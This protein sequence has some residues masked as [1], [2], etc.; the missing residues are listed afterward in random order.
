MF[1]EIALFCVVI[2]LLFGYWNVNQIYA[3][4]LK[5]NIPFDKGQFPYGN[6]KDVGEKMHIFELTNNLY[7]R[8]KKQAPVAG[9]HVLT[10]AAV[11]VTDLDVVKRILVSD[12]NLFMDRGIYR[13]EEDPLSGN[14]FNLDG[15]KYK[16]MHNKL[17][18]LFS[19]EKIKLMFQSMEEFADRLSSYFFDFIEGRP[20]DLNLQDILARYSS[21][22]MGTT[23]LGSEC[24]SLRDETTELRRISKK[25]LGKGRERGLKYFF[26][27]TFQETAK[28]IKMTETPKE[29]SDFFVRL[30][31]SSIDNRDTTKPKKN[32]LIELLMS[33]NTNEKSGSLTLHETSAHAYI[34]Y[35][36]GFETLTNTLAFCLYEISKTREIQEILRRQILQVFKHKADQASYDSINEIPYLDQVINETL[37]KHPPAPVLFRTATSDYQL[38]NTNMV[39]PMGTQI[40]I[41]VYAIHHDETIYTKPEAYN[42]DR[43]N[44]DNMKDGHACSFMPF[45]CGPRACIGSKFAMMHLKITLVNLLRKFRFS[46]GSKTPFPLKFD[47]KAAVLSADDIWLT[48]ENLK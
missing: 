26:R 16:E 33:E 11:V 35:V 42:P 29:V 10:N 36:A 47:K 39:I 1:I 45:S 40:M 30:V 3:I 15:P 27:N 13:N 34:F 18:P 19:T 48:V 46:I 25:Y 8:M 17:M 32:N 43:F 41:P 4:W 6:M 38:P 24:N 37:R 9:F 5:C 31:K 21:D 20:T 22:V 23:F 14:L 12:S 7:K 28:R 44:K 2:A